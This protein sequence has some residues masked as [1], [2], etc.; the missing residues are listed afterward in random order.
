MI[1]W[2]TWEA[3]STNSYGCI[4]MFDRTVCVHTEISPLHDSLPVYNMR[5]VQKVLAI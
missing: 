5:S 2:D 4:Y 3:A 1:V